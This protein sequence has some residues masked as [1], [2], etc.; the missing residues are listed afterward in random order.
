[1][2]RVFDNLKE[3]LGTALRDSLSAFDR[4][5]VAVGYF[6]LRG[7]SMLDDL[8]HSK[9]TEGAAQPVVRILIGMV[10]KD[11]H[12]EV[13]DELQSQV[14]RSVETQ[15]EADPSDARAR[16][17]ELLAHLRDQLMRGLPTA[18]DRLTLQSLRQLVGAGVV[19]LKVYTY[20]P[21]HGKTYIFHRE[22]KANPRIAFVGSSN[23]TRAGL[24]SNLELNVDV[25]DHQ[26]SQVLSS[27]FEDLWNDKFSREIST[28][29][30]DLLDESWATTKTRRPYEVYL[31]VCYDLSRD[32]REGLAE[33]SL[34]GRIANELLEY[35]ATAVKTLARRI[36]TR[37]GT[38][39]GDVVGL[40]KTLTAVAV[41]LMLRDEHGYQPLILCPKNLTSMWEEHLEAYDLHGRVISYSMVHHHLPELRRYPFV[42]LDESHTLRNSDRRDYTVIRDYME[43]NESKALLLTGTPYNLRFQDVANQLALYLE[44]DQDLGITPVNAL[45]IDPK[46]IDRVDGKTSTLLAFRQSEDPEDW[47]RLMGEH[48]VRRTRSFIRA[49]HAKTDESGRDYLEFSDGSRFVF[50]TRI[51]IPINHTF[52]PDDPAGLM[53]SDETLDAL[54]DL[55][56]PRYQ[57]GNYVSKTATLTATEESLVQDLARARAQ[58]AGFVR[59]NFYKRLA[60]CGHSFIVSL[61]RHV[62]RNEIFLHAIDNDLELPIGTID[63]ASLE[64]DRESDQDTEDLTF[65]GVPAGVD[66]GARYDALVENDPR[67]IRW[68]RPGIFTHRLRE[69]LLADTANLVGLLDW[70]GQWTHSQD[71]KLQ[72]LLRMLNED[73]PD[74]KVL[75]FTEYKDTAEY[76]YRALE[77]AGVSDVAV[78]TGQTENPTGLAHRFA[79]IANS[80][81]TGTRT[82]A[83]EL[84]V[85]IATDVLSEGQNLQDAHIVVNYDLPWAIIRL[86]QRAGRVDR[87]G[88]QSETVYVY[89]A[90][91]ES[92]DATLSLRQRIRERLASNAE[93]FG[94]DEQFFGTEDEVRT[95]HEMFSGNMAD[96]EDSDDVD[97]TSLAYQ[98]WQNAQKNHPDVAEKI[99]HLPD[100]ID[101]TRTIRLNDPGEGVLCYVRTSSGLDGFGRAFP[102]GTTSLMT[103]HETLRAFEAS[104]TEDGMERRNDHDDL[105]AALVHGPLAEPAS[106]AGRL[107]GVRRTLWNRLNTLA[108]TKDTEAQAALDALY[109]SPLTTTTTR[110]LRRD[111]RNGVSDEDLLARLKRLHREGTLVVTRPTGKDPIRIVSTMGVRS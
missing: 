48:L 17:A 36:M 104:P 23:F 43:T 69:D 92:L 107:R 71:S 50:P 109:Q 61:R 18:K 30:L 59:T 32:V 73:H 51:P 29:L 13:I 94:S 90:F 20:R 62:A 9:A 39:L 81:L 54:R 8:A 63:D 76:L 16:K 28:E 4:L 25:V 57:L 46:I 100:L 52:G 111:I 108:V 22:D 105:L 98:I 99:P 41:A 42:I 101:A 35:Q 58:V 95:I 80:R 74:E 102:D 26:G 106:A 96:L 49:N 24:T 67:G 34:E 66:V 44:E 56:L 89:S 88:Q 87:V 14:D 7:W 3:D 97:A 40:G 55:R 82:V 110:L 86:I 11:Q 21:L 91:H 5:D 2:A 68:T 38:M 75:V 65:D 64:T 27:W 37:R 1:M 19:A 45:K 31:K 79:P 77:Q 78:A 83:N 6:D 15:M 85:L 53:A 84:R 60:S 103:G 33:Y 12:R 47:K 72:A 70:Y 10:M 93:A